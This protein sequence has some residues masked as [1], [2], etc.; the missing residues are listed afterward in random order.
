MTTELE[1]FKKWMKETKR[2]QKLIKGVDE[3]RVALKQA[4]KEEK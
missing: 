4:R 3:L 2:Y 1:Q